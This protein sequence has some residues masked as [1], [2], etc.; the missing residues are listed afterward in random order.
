MS[1]NMESY[2]DC[3]SEEGITVGLIDAIISISRILAKRDLST[4]SAKQGLLD[5]RLDEDVFHITTGFPL[6]TYDR[7]YQER[8][9]V[10][11]RSLDE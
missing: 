11:G 2:T 9:D 5:L 6:L 1:N 7:I 4:E 3:R 8:R 10:P